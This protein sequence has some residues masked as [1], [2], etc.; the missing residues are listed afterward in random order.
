MRRTGTD[1][2]GEILRMYETALTRFGSRVHAVG[3]R[4]DAPT[5]C[6]DWSVRDL[7]N[8]LAVEQLW[9]PPLVLEGSPIE[10][11]RGRWDGDRLGDDPV[12]AW[13]EAASAALAAFN[14]PGALS[15]IVHLSAGNSTAAA[16]CAQ[17]TMDAAVHGWDLSRAL[18]LDATLPPALV[19]FC[20]AEIEP[21]ADELE[22]SGLFAAPVKVPPGAGDQTRLLAVL[23]RRA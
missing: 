10:A 15:R 11:Q 18:D 3:D 1:E 21:Y 16:Y 20:L 2:H 4:W 14:A 12:G 7:V 23:G 17:M 5:P 13:D 22:A 8:H 6:A 19:A 9:V